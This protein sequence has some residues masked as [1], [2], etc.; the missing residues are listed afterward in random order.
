MEMLLLLGILAGLVWLIRR[1]RPKKSLGEDGTG[2]WYLKAGK[3]IGPVTIDTLREIL[4]HDPDAA[5]IQVWRSGFADW[6]LARDVPI[7]TGAAE[8][9]PPII[10]APL[11]PRIDWSRVLKL[12]TALAACYVLAAVLLMGERGGKLRPLV[13]PNAVYEINF[14]GTVGT[15][16]TSKPYNELRRDISAAI[17]DHAGALLKSGKR[18]EAESIGDAGKRSDE[19]IQQLAAEN[20][21]GLSQAYVALGTIVI[22]PPAIVLVFAII[23]GRIRRLGDILYSAACVL[24]VLCLAL[25]WLVYKGVDTTGIEVARQHGHS[26]AQILEQ[27]KGQDKH[28]RYDEARTHGYSPTQILDHIVE[29]ERSYDRSALITGTIAALLCWATG[30]GIRSVLRRNAGSSAR[31]DQQQG[32]EREQ[33]AERQG[34]PQ[35][36]EA[37]KREREARERQAEQR[38]TEQ[39]RQ[40]EQERDAERRGQP[41]DEAKTCEDQYWWDVLDVSPDAN[42]SDIRGSYLRKM[43]QYHPDRVAGLAPELIELAERRTKSLNGAYAEALSARRREA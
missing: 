6:V 17:T 34:H 7:L 31:Q 8:R 19:L 32:I 11:G 3:A 25:G 38:R 22:L 43:R 16:D 4:I 27:R 15:F 9:P 1:S 39:K 20:R 41:E 12:W 40:A 26:D 10:T 33:Q 18:A 14:H 28:F 42:T 5:I 35:Q 37:E 21:A 23:I 30:L 13:N 24:A 36:S 2:W 29:H